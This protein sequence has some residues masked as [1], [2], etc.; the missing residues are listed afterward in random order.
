MLVQQT[1]L[2]SMHCL[3]KL[4]TVKGEQECLERSL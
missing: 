4:F 1:E 3:G 2:S